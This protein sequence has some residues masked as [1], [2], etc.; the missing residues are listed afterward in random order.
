MSVLRCWCVVVR[1]DA[2][3]VAGEWD[4]LV[5]HYLGADHVGHSFHVRHPEMGRKLADY[6]AAVRTTMSVL[7]ADPEHAD[8]LLLVFGDHGALPL[9]Q[10]QVDVI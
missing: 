7:S 8:T 10:A 5:A 1:R 3:A 2:F 4:V 6:A 9:P